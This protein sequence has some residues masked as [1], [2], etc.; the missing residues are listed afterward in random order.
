LVFS[1]FYE[2]AKDL[3]TSYENIEQIEEGNFGNNNIEIIGT[4]LLV[5]ENSISKMLEGFS[6]DKMEETT[7]INFDVCVILYE[8]VISSFFY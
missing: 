2:I 8:P 7:S 4:H 5:P 3:P 6:A 1:E